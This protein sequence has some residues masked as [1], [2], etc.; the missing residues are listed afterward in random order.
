MRSPK[1][2]LTFPKKRRAQQNGIKLLRK[3]SR[4]KSKNAVFVCRVTSLSLFA[5]MKAKNSLQ[6]LIQ[7][8][9]PYKKLFVFAIVL[10]VLLS[11]L[12]VLRPYVVQYILDHPVKE[13]DFQGLNFW[14][15]VFLGLLIFNAFTLYLQRLSTNVLAQKIIHGLRLKVFKHIL[16]LNLS[17]FNKTPVGVLQTRTIGDIQTL[18][19]VFSNA[20]ISIVADTL[21]VFFVLG[22]MFYT[23][24]KLTLWML[25]P[26]AAILI[27][28]YIFKVKVKKVFN[29]VREY[30]SRLNAFLQERI[31]GMLLIKVFKQQPREAKKF[32]ILNTT[33]EQKHIKTILYYSIFF[34]VI[35]FI[36]AFS[37]AMIITFGGKYLLGTEITLGVLVAFIMYLRLLFRPIRI[38]ADQFN[39]LQLGIV[40]A[41]RIF[42][43]LDTQEK[44]PQISGNEEVPKQF[45][46]AFKEVFFGYTSEK[47]VLKN[48]S[49]SLPEGRTY[50]LV[51]RTGSGKSTLFS[52]LMRFYDPQKGKILLGGT[53]IRNFSLST[54]RSNI[55]LVLQ[56]S[57]MFDDTLFENI[58]LYD[59]NISREQVLQS[60]KDLQLSEFIERFPGGL[61]FVTGERGNNLSLGE[62]QLV[63]MLRITVHN[64]KVLLLDEATANLDSQTEKLLQ[65]A[66]EKITQDRTVLVIAH[67]LSTIQNVD[68]ILVMQ[69]GEIVEA[70][71]HKELLNK[72]GYYAKLHS[73]SLSL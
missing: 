70:G 53:D 41:N 26:L 54:L 39:T 66:L 16:S 21:Q 5:P 45:S 44:I 69:N 23:S 4:K 10:S 18:E 9:L 65:N 8:I 64:P 7:L 22:I 30:V 73:Y 1:N 20:F 55:G 17:F 61:D 51:G 50:A 29:E 27:A 57:L 63:G 32:D 11:V 28:S 56:E 3:L 35:E 43:I 52:L 15:L 60:V 33:L 67:R 48:I 14:S 42:R 12:T 58:R 31:T 59:E 6:R 37:I 36:H 71:S 49:F 62:K 24:V 38:L 72:Q 68:K 34:P 2:V 19:K 46:I 25:I 47:Q 13:K 40:C